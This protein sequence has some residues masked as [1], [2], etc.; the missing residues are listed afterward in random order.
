MNIKKSHLPS[1]SHPHPY[2]HTEPIPAAAAADSVPAPPASRCAARCA[3]CPRACDSARSRGGATTRPP[4]PAGRPCRR[5]ARRA[6]EERINSEQRIAENTEHVVEQSRAEEDIADQRV[7]YTDKRYKEKNAV[8]KASECASAC[9]RKVHNPRKSTRGRDIEITR[10]KHTPARA[11]SPTERAP[12]C[13]G[14]RA[15]PAR[16]ADSVPVRRPLMDANESMQWG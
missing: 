9:V 13:S 8:K 2:T 1:L 10:Y 5:Y 11:F 16:R 3:Q 7:M 15:R 14:S 4:R 12:Q 6:D